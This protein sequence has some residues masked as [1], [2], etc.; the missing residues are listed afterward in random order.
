MSMCGGDGDGCHD[1]SI[2]RMEKMIAEMNTVIINN[3]SLLDS[4][5]TRLM[6]FKISRT[7]IMK[8][9][10]GLSERIRV[11]EDSIA[12]SRES[13]NVLEADKNA[14]LEMYVCRPL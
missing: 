12:N 4:Y 11:L 3:S 8:T 6:T 9:I 2:C 7:S 1:N 10:E 13:W 14:I 5:N